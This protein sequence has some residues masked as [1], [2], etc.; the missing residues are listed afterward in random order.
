MARTVSRTEITVGYVI[1][2]ALVTIASGVFLSQFRYSPAIIESTVIE[3]QSSSISPFHAGT[4]GDLSRFAPNGLT[5]PSTPEIYNPENLSDKINGKAELYLSAGF[6]R[7]LTQR[8]AASDNPGA[9]LEVY[10][11][12]MGSLR[13]AFAVYSMQRR[14]DA[15]EL[16]LADFAYHTENA[17]FFVHGPYYVEIIAS[18][19][20][21]KLAE[22]M[23]AVGRDFIS[24]IQ[25]T[26]DRITE[27]S[28]FPSEH[29]NRGA[30]ALLPTDAFGFHRFTSIF[31]A[32]YAVEGT[33]LT[34]FVSRRES[35]SEA[36]EL[37]VAY[38]RF[39]VTNGGTE[40]SSTVEIPQAKLVEIMDTFELVF[41]RSNL[42]A[43]VH[44]AE[45]REAAEKLGRLL[46]RKL[47][48]V[49]R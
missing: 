37:V 48:E 39:L 45:N 26:R 8:F 40:L 20:Q 33:E 30:F 29:L 16:E 3:K 14:F 41:S 27:L 2:L 44:G 17:L 4:L 49:V 21:K 28:L 34:A 19:G 6:R 24:K 32:Q 5:P 23:L 35:E 11:Y 15:E 9:W 36:A 12:N 38:T 7:L 43:G 47:Q 1:L 42:L 25:V 10:V 31:T 18:I 46:G 22:S 13:Q